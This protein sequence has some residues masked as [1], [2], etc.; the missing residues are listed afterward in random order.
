M[1]EA[2]VQ[3]QLP[4]TFAIIGAGPAGLGAARSFL[5]LGLEVELIERHSQPGGIWNIDNPGSPMYASCNFISSRDYGGF[6]DFPM[7]SEYPLY[8][9]WHQIRD[10][11]HSFADAFSLR[12]RTRFSTTVTNAEPIETPGGTY[13]RVSF[14]DGTTTDYRGVVIASGAQW[15]PIL[16]SVPG[17]D[18]F[19]GRLIHSSEYAD[20]DELR[21][22][23]VLVVGAGNSGVDIAADAA[24]FG[25]DAMLSTRRA[26][27]F[28]PKV[29]FGRSVP[30]ILNGEYEFPE[31]HPLH[32]ASFERACEV[33]FESVGEL[34]NYG[35]PR[36]DHDFGLTHPI[37]NNEALHCF[38]HNMLRWKPDLASID[39]DTVTFMDGSTETPDVIVFATGYDVT[40]PYLDEG[41]LT[42]RDGHP[43]TIVGALIDGYEGLYM[44]GALHFPGNTFPTFEQC[45]QLAAHDARALVTGENAE[46]LARLRAE[47]RPDLTGGVPLLESRRNANQVLLPAL[48]AAFDEMEERYGV[49]A[50]RRT[51]RG[52]FDRLRAPS[53]T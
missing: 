49:P 5:S 20:P 38:A 11:I 33:I 9:K 45:A 17:A 37:A 40:T 48:D 10:Y 29:L 44:A 6:I 46:N 30:D 32:N 39:G 23:R 43:E 21:H 51:D 8:P 15:Q 19:T 13:W 16:P 31:G 22:E 24:H 3:A 50:L 34:A 27:W 41:I 53:A 42:Y 52:R 35:L 25:A 2:T 28:L 14:D 26:Y 12:E 47:Y 36:P 7:P 4:T 1:S 18:S